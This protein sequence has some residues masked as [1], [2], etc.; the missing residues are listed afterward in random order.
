MAQCRVFVAS[1]SESREVARAIQAELYEDAAVI[2]WDQDQTPLSASVW[3][4]LQD[5]AS[6]ADFAVFVLAPD[7][8]SIIRSERRRVVRDNV[9]FEFGLFVGR[10]GGHRCFGLKP[11]G[12]DIHLP[13]DL[14]GLTL[15]EYRAGLLETEARAA[16]GPFCRQVR[17]SL[18]S[19]GRRNPESRELFLRKVEPLLRGLAIGSLDLQ[20]AAPSPVD[21]P[22]VSLDE[23]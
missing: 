19:L 13:S 3:E 20:D 12:V 22:G 21:L 14:A 17:R 2:V 11:A 9:V 15:G 10:L 4:A 8:E 6:R 5:E 7:D 18:H 16:V 1:S 23:E